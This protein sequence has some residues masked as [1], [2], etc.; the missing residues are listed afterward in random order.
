MPGP[1]TP[2]TNIGPQHPVLATLFEQA[3]AGGRATLD[4]AKR[5]SLLASF[6]LALV[7][8][9]AQAASTAVSSMTRWRRS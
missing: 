9:G 5:A 6:E 2:T 4:T 1:T 7:A 3:A 8:D